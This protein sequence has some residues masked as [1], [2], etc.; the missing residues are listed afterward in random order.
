MK[1]LTSVC[2]VA[3][4]LPIAA[5]ADVFIMDGPK[6]TE[7]AVGYTYL[8]ANA[9]PG[10][11]G[12]FSMNGGSF[13]VAQPIKSENFAALFD[14]TLLHASGISPGKYDLTLSVFSVGG[15]YR[16]W[17]ESRWSPFAQVLLGGSHASGTLVEGNTP[18]AR[19]G[20]LRF[21]STVGGGIDYWLND[22]WSIRAFEA[23]YVLTTYANRTNDRQNNLRISVG[24]AF[25]FGAP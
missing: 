17:P 23:D 2:L 7:V 15:R 21:A 13:S 18:A 10:E 4:G 6:S 5:S 22:R 3:L 14:A 25:H 8:R 16:P 12:C 11:C 1:I 20:G 24:A 9:P 19:D